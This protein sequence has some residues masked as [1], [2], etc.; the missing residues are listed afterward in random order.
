LDVA[1]ATIWIWYIVDEVCRFQRFLLGHIP[2]HLV[3][4]GRRCIV[5]ATVNIFRQIA[6]LHEYNMI[7]TIQDNNGGMCCPSCVVYIMQ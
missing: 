7:S 3:A 4:H 1:K 6:F 5:F 2:Y